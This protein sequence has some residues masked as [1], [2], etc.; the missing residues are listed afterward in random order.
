MNTSSSSLSPISPLS[1]SLSC[2]GINASLGFCT[3][4]I[5]GIFWTI[6]EK[7]NH[8]CQKPIEI[9]FERVS[10]WQRMEKFNDI[11]FK[12]YLTIE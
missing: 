8:W 11:V 12:K 6:I 10:A 1:Q 4:G 3:Y 9:E 5:Y 7:K 2:L